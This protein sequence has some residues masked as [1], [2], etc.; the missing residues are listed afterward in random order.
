M[1]RIEM[2]FDPSDPTTW[3][4]ESWHFQEHRSEH[5][6][7]GGSAVFA[8]VTR[9][10]IPDQCFDDGYIMDHEEYASM[11]KKRLIQTCRDPRL[12][13]RTLQPEQ[14]AENAQTIAY[15]IYVAFAFG[16]LVLLLDQI[17]ITIVF[18]PILRIVDQN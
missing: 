8:V 2:V 3:N 14:R 16:K 12:C 18:P 5:Y 10:S 11:L 17:T 1:R 4:L 7:N 6:G 13:K 15:A 9:K